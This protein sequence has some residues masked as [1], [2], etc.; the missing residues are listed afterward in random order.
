MKPYLSLCLLFR[1]N[2]A[3][4][5]ALIE[6][7]RGKFD[8]VVACDTGSTDGSRALLEASGARIVDFPW[9][10][11]FAAARQFAFEQASGHWRCFLDSDDVLVGS[12]REY[13]M[14]LEA[15]NPVAEA[16]FVP[17]EYGHLETLP[18]MRIVRWRDGWKWTD[19]IH[20]RLEFRYP[21]GDGLPDESFVRT[22]AFKVQH[23][24]KTP[25]EK[26]AAIH[27]NARIAEK[28]YAT[29]TDPKY[30]ARLGRTIAME[31]KMDGK[32]AETIP[33]LEELH[34]H[35]GN[36]P[37][38]KQGAADIM[39]AYLHLAETEPEQAL[40]SLDS[41]LFWSK[42]AGP[43]YEAIAHHA[44]GEWE[45]CLKASQ[46]SLGRGQQTTHEG[47][48]FEQAACYVA[49]AISAWKLGRDASV[50]ENCLNHIAPNLRNEPAIGEFLGSLRQDIDR[51]TIVVPGTPQPF[52]ENG[53]GGMLGGSEEAVVYLSRALAKAGRNV[54]IYG[55]LPPH[56]VPG[57]DRFGVDWQPISAFESRLD[58]EMGTLVVWRAP[59]LM[60]NLMQ[61]AGQRKR[62][63]AGIGQSFLWL[64]DSGLGVEPQ[65]AKIVGENCEGAVV[66][67]DFH[68]KMVKRAGFE[69]KFWLASNGIVEEDFEPWID[70]PAFGFECSG[71]CKQCDG[72]GDIY[73][74]G[75]GS[76]NAVT[77]G[78]R[79]VFRDPYSV[80][81]SSCPS[82]GLVPLL[83]MWPAIKE[84]VPQAAL[85]IYYDW[86]MLEA[87]QPHAFDRVKRAHDAV[88]HLDVVHHGGV[89]HATLHAALR[90]ANIW[91]YSHFES[92][93][94][95]T[96]CISAVKAT[97][98]GATV[99]TVPN[100]ALPEV[101]PDA[102]FCRSVE[103]Y[104]E[105]LI[106]YLLNPQGIE[107][108]RLRARRA[109]ER[110]GWARVA[111]RFSRIWSVSNRTGSDSKGLDATEKGTSV[112][113]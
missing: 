11:D 103:D 42:C 55:V 85:D 72:P 21:D 89:D 84:A 6:S 45:Q 66:L 50:A 29:T 68:G 78:P 107:L 58:D 102:H 27:R 76:N 25:E 61:V 91:A 52:D 71:P 2:V 88:K 104:Q 40:T 26:A 13:L 64:H 97:A 73:P 74:D 23:K 37:E 51:I 5:P 15:Q 82:R 22:T 35:Y 4:L 17:Y 48:I 24:D 77:R 112:A 59:G 70:E 105:Q 12:P 34:A 108:R 10:D 16:V 98:A 63:F 69:G 62:P 49:A 109:L 95:E 20:E 81:Y 47:L 44:R 67:S 46:R 96:F 43:A 60:L 19:A 90:R 9:I 41:A 36:Y 18:T 8:E 86:S 75:C 110:F 79:Q 92:T 101:A 7:I 100:G 99:L 94:V 39:K 31:L 56:R 38:G 65:A 1:D 32:A 28:E 113:A 93:D 57:P 80:V 87:M 30:R 53:G 54:R 111:A 14:S 33:Y 106:E 83:E 3:T